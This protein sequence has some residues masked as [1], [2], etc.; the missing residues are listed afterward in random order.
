VTRQDPRGINLKGFAIGNG[1][2]GIGNVG[3]CGV[4]SMQ[5]FEAFGAGHGLFSQTL[6][7]QASGPDHYS[8]IPPNR[9]ECSTFQHSPSKIGSRHSD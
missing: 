8:S 4:D 2:N 3:A 7:E 9:T 6:H 1:C 5:N